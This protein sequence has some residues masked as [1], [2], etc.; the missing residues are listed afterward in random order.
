MDVSKLI[1]FKIEESLKT[2]SSGYQNNKNKASECRS[3]LYLLTGKPIMNSR[4]ATLCKASITPDLLVSK[5]LDNA[6]NVVPCPKP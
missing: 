4:C 3:S 1:M 2:I 5:F 6:P